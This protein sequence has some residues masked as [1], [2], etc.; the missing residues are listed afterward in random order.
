MYITCVLIRSKDKS[1]RYFHVWAS[2]SFHC[3]KEAYQPLRIV[4]TVLWEKFNP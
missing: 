1:A 2:N 3:E 4:D